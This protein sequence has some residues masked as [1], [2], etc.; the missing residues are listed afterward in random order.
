ML[1]MLFGR[2][3]KH[4]NV[5][6]LGETEVEFS[7]DVHEALERL[8]GVSQAERHVRNSNRPKGVIMAV[9]GMSSG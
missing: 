6:H 3:G 9:F 4:E 2:Q 7:Q 8:G 5:I 1:L